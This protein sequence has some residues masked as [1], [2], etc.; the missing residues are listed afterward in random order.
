MAETP[1]ERRSGNT[2]SPFSDA[3]LSTLKEFADLM[4][5]P[6]HSRFLHTANE[7]AARRCCP[8]GCDDVIVDGFYVHPPSECARGRHV[9]DGRAGRRRKKTAELFGRSVRAFFRT[10]SNCFARGYFDYSPVT[11]VTLRLSSGLDR[12]AYRR[13]VRRRTGRR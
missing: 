12:S 9:F 11:G 3:A 7:P 10:V 13:R 8:R 2:A 5:A 1:N 4:G 6:A